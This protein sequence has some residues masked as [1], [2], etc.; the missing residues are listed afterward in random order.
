MGARPDQDRRDR[1][2][3]ARREGKTLQAIAREM[4]CSY[5]NVSQLLRAAG[6]T[7]RD[8]SLVRPLVPGRRRCAEC[9]Y[10]MM[11]RRPSK[12]NRRTEYRHDKRAHRRAAFMRLLALDLTT[13]EVA[14][15]MKCGMSTVY[16]MMRVA[17]RKGRQVNVI[18]Q[19]RR[20][21]RKNNAV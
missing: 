3:A 13:S 12:Q 6:K 21:K 7:C 1:A 2:I 19:Q 8:C 20:E 14:K 15:R 17:E 4:G 16:Y 18:K 10:R 11:Q 5:Q 9:H